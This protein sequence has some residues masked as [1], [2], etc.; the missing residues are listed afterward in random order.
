MRFLSVLIVE[1]PVRSLFNA[2]IVGG[3]L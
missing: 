2:E 3:K 1:S